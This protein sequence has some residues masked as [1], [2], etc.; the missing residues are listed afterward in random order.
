MLEHHATHPFVHSVAVIFSSLLQPTDRTKRSPC[1]SLGFYS[2]QSYCKVLTTE[3]NHSLLVPQ[4]TDLTYNCNSALVTWIVLH[5]GSARPSVWKALSLPGDNL[6]EAGGRSPRSTEWLF[7]P[8]DA[9]CCL[10]W[11]KPREKGKGNWPL[12]KH[13]KLLI[14]VLSQNT[15][16]NLDLWVTS[17]W[18]P[19]FGWSV[20]ASKR[21]CE[22]LS[23]NYPAKGTYLAGSV[24]RACNAWS[25]D[26]KLEPYVG[27]RDY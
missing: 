27:C 14:R 15:F 6:Q 26:H 5:E 9:H 10:T 8:S 3:W 18:N 13:I 11:R 12:R 16:L 2:V 21:P 23:S 1:L 20:P 22:N 19:P 7:P 25:Q 24:R 4:R 17:R